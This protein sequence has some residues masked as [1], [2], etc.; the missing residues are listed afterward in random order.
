MLKQKIESRFCGFEPGTNI[1]LTILAIVAVSPLI[2]LPS[3]HLVVPAGC[4]IKMYVSSSH[5]TTLSSS[6][7]NSWSSHC[8]SPSSRCATLSSSRCASLLS[9]HSLLL[10]IAYLTTHVDAGALAFTQC[11]NLPPRHLP[12]R[13]FG[14]TSQNKQHNIVR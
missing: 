3:R 2:T 12:P 11:E 4:R 7:H 1:A 10:D 6:C 14:E 13:H 8:L 5:C 9:H